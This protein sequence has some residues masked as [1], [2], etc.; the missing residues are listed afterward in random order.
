MKSEMTELK[1]QKP[2][3][4]A[5][6]AYDAVVVGSGPNGLS[7]AIVLAREGLSVLVIEA[8]ETIGGGART[9]EITEPGFLHD[10]C[11]AIHPVG[12]VSPFF[13]SIE[14][15]RWGV[16]WVY[17]PVALAHPFDDDSAA[18]MYKSLDDTARSLGADAEAYVDLMKPFVDNADKLI[19]EILKPV[20]VPRHPLLMARFGLKALRSCLGLTRSRFRE[21][22]AKALFAGCAAHSIL[23]LDNVGTASF[24]LILALSAHVIGWPAARGGSV[25]IIN[26]L[27]EC[28][29]S[30]G[31][32]IITNHPV[33]SIKDLPETRSVLFDLTPRQVVAIAGDYFPARYR[34]QLARYRYG[35]G[36]FKIDWALDGPIPWK[37]KDC[38]RAATVHLAGTI[39]EIARG[40]AEVWEGKHPDR[41]FVL[42][43]QQS[44]FDDSRAP[45]GK[46][47]GWAYCHVPHASQVDMTDAIERQ[48]ERFAPGF[49]DLI[50]VRHTFTA[51]QIEEHNPNMIG[52]DIGGGANFISQFLL[53]PVPRFDPYST[54]N[55]KIYICS[56]S[57]PP[58]G[59]VHGMC[60][61]WAARSALKTVF[62]KR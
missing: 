32:E 60:G 41:P 33:R 4:S 5:A 50:R 62:G 26:A 37:V 49:R 16:E 61:Y 40:E 9:E 51:A 22:W 36:V 30:L 42:V 45:A 23:P 35:P 52:G 7:A 34:N 59:G 21:K 56:S 27:A 54:P 31:G 46:R 3:A 10:I 43:T 38:A 53:R 25:S 18:L 47:T 57:T 55:T 6:K 8:K 11:S 58:G 29:K 44:D 39:E 13:K 48:I 19:S 17:S 12:V 24:G 20:R 2:P 15:E 14:L 1:F 28:F